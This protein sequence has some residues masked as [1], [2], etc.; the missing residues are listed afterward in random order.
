M[1]RIEASRALGKVFAY[2]ACGKP[3]KARPFA[4]QLIEWLQSI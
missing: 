2:L 1:D 4:R 3:D